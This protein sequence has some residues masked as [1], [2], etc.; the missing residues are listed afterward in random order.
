VVFQEYV[1]ELS[2][3]S[4]KLLQKL[5]SEPSYVKNYIEYVYQKIQE[6]EWIYLLYG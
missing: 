5:E 3:I 1:K 6:K 4:V 2:N